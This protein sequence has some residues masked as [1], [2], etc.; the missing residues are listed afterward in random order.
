VQRVQIEARHNWQ[1]WCEKLGFDFHTIGQAYWNESAYYRFEEYEIDRIDDATTELWGMYANALEYVLQNNLLAQVGIPEEYADWV[2]HSWQRAD[3]SLY[4]RFDLA[5]DG[6]NLKLLEFNADTP[7]SLFEASAVQ[8]HW[9]QD[10][11]GDGFDQFNWIH[12]A[13][14]QVFDQIGTGT[15]NLPRRGLHFACMQGTLEDYRTVEY[16]MDVALQRG[17]EP[18]FVHIEDIHWNGTRFQDQ[19]G[20]VI[21]GIFKLYPYEFLFRDEFGHA[22]PRDPW[23]MLEPPW[24]AIMSSKGLLPILWE[25]HPNHPLLLPASFNDHDISSWTV[26]KPVF[27]REGANVTIRHIGVDTPGKYDEF[28]HVYQG[29]FELPRFDGFYPVL[30]SWVVGGAACGLGIREDTTPVT[31]DGASF[32]PHAFRS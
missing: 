4:G 10:V 7:T 5:Y 11:L 31:G 27:S 1:Q 13:L 2:K 22:L 26:R 16:L 30:G 25:N 18:R 6:S 19:T 3:Q 15:T 24:K 9:L 29:F 12:E 8:W 28:G 17:L 23:A 20:S 32:V 21:E 14:E